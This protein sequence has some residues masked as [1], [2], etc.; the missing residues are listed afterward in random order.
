MI[1][2]SPPSG[3]TDSGNES[4]VSLYSAGAFMWGCAIFAHQLKAKSI[5]NLDHQFFLT[6]A[7][8]WLILQPWKVQRLV[9]VAAI[10]IMTAIMTAPWITNH[11][12]FVTLVNVGILTSYGYSRWKKG[13]EADDPETIYTLI[14]PPIRIS[15]IL[16]YFYVTL[17]KCT[18]GFFDPETSCGTEMYAWLRNKLPFLPSTTLTD[19]A[20]IYGTL[21][22]EALIPLLLIVRRTRRF[23]IIFGWLF[24]TLLTLNLFFAFAMTMYAGYAFFLPSDFGDRWRE[25][26]N[27]NAICGSIWRNWY[28]VA[29][30]PGTFP[31]CFGLLA[32]L[33]IIGIAADGRLEQL[34]LR[35]GQMSVLMGTAFLAMLL[36]LAFW[37]QP[38]VPIQNA[39]RVPHLIAWLSPLLILLNGLSPYLGLKTENS[40]T[41]FSN[42][43]TEGNL[44]NQLVLP[45]AMRVFPF[46]DDLVK[47]EASSDPRFQ[48]AAEENSRYVYW[49][50]RRDA[51][52][53]PEA[54]VQYLYQGKYYD[55]ARIA[56]DPILGSPVDPFLKKF[57]WF[58]LVAD[59]KNNGCGH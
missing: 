8:V 10:Q 49:H 36:V 17:A 28:R 6:V 53:R 40:F 21:V 20:S 41:M 29:S 19:Y 7:S 25:L 1:S 57:I 9:L 38:A 45:Q 26:G 13:D 54:S 51:S 12:M 56:D 22:I 55:V 42:V 31:A 35:F 50:F 4:V 44:W 47:I 5:F 24:H 52:D 33:G 27:R 2:D 37:R 34:E 11:W 43:Q 14:A 16:L 30:W 58:R 32:V 39:F 23:A 59:P 18:V 15:L 46:Q 3:K 48:R